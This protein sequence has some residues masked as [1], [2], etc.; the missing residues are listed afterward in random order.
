MC[1]TAELVF[2]KKSNAIVLKWINKVE[3]KMNLM[4]YSKKAFPQT[5]MKK[6]FCF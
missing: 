5:P 4:F 1:Q 3:K 2:H 6:I